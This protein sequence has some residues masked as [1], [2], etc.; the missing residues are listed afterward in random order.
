MS[1]EALTRMEQWLAAIEA[2]GAPGT[3]AAR[4]LRNRPVELTDACWT[5]ATNRISEPFGLAVAGACETLYPTFGD[6]R[7]AAGSG[8][9]NDTL[10]CRLQ[11]LDVASYGVAF[12]ASQQTRLQTVFPGGVCDWTQ[13]GVGKVAPL[14]TWLDYR[15]L[16]R[17]AERGPVFPPA[18]VRR[19]SVAESSSALARLARWPRRQSSSRARSAATPPG[20]GSASA[21]AATPSARSSRR[22]PPPSRSAPR[23]R[24]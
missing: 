11:P 14:G 7:R 4:T 5:S 24:C 17:R 3:D 18:R 8:L 20:A 15:E 22:R 1:V 13:P 21:R 16:D 10:K 12:S 19:S 6:T 23:S 9:A 2:D